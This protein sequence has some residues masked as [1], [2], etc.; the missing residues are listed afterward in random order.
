MAELTSGSTEIAA[1]PGQIMEVL[2]DFG[3]YP[4]WAGVKSA[5]VLDKDLEGRPAEVAMSVSQMGFEASYT[6]RYEYA[7]ANAGVSWTTREAT[8]VLKDIRGSYALKP[9]GES[10]TVTSSPPCGWPS[11]TPHTRRRRSSRDAP[12]GCSTSAWTGGS[13]PLASATPPAS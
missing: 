2:T 8:G 9:V 11:C 10:T 4:Q 12:S 5:E 13:T 6:L 3:A 7:P 1:S